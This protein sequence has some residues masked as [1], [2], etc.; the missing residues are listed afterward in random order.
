M[1]L[2]EYVFELLI[3][4]LTVAGVKIDGAVLVE[5]DALGVPPGDVDGIRFPPAATTFPGSALPITR[6][7]ARCTA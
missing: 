6:S 1:H 7:A 3:T 2:L 5:V 4:I